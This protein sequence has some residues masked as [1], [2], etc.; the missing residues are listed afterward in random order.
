M[1]ASIGQL[2]ILVR[3]SIYLNTWKNYVGASTEFRKTRTSETNETTIQ[4]HNK[5][6]P[7]RT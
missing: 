7:F 4:F 1:F 5:L 2:E 3:V 6:G